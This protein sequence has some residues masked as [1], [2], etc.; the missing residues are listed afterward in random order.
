MNNPTYLGFSILELTK[1]I[2]YETY[3]D[4]LEPYFA[5]KNLQLHYMDTDSP[6]LGVNTKD[7]IIDLKNLEDLF[8]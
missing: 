1:L 3:Y 7:N 5:D 4:K 6:V 2:M 8:D